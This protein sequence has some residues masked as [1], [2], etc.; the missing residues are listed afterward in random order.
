MKVWS[1]N[2]S[3]NDN[4]LFLPRENLRLIMLSYNKKNIKRSATINVDD[5]SFIL[6]RYQL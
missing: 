6:Q 1:R 2:N 5:Q 4:K 3:D